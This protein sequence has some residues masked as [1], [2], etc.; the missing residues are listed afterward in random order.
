MWQL[1]REHAI[2]R[3]AIKK[4]VDYVA[5]NGWIDHWI[6]DWDHNLHLLSMIEIDS[7]FHKRNWRLI[8]VEFFLE[9]LPQNVS[10]RPITASFD[11][12]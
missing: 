3:S 8:P 12:T 4:N 1:G 7:F 6:G 11:Q 2:D 10:A 9:H 5:I